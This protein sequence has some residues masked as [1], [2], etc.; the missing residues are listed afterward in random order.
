MVPKLILQPLVENAIYHGIKPARKTCALLVK[1]IR[2]GNELTLFVG[3]NGV[4]M[5]E[6]KAVSILRDNVTS[7]KHMGG[8]GV[9]NINERIAL[10]YGEEFGIS[11]HCIEQIGTLAV[12]TLPAN[13]AATQPRN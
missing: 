5:K 2:D 11:Y 13:P 7:E 10:H 1:A 6:E 3:D 4:G 8:I 9:K 12:V